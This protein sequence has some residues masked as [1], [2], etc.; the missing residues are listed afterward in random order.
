MLK[1][2]CKNNIIPLSQIR[3]ST[4]FLREMEFMK[5]SKLI[6]PVIITVMLILF[7]MVYCAVWFLI[8]VVPSFIKVILLLIFGGLTGVS[9]FNLYE[10][11]CEIRSG[12]ED[13]LSK[14]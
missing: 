8:P 4:N 11:I 14:Y 1:Y 5:Y 10:R 6:A 3:L 7:L 12:E 9:I 13:D 2:F